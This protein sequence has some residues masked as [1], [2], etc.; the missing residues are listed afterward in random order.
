APAAAAPPPPRR[1]PP[2][3]SMSLR[4]GPEEAPTFAGSLDDQAATLVEAA[5]GG[6]PFCAMCAL[7]ALALAGGA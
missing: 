2:G 3:P 7:K 1:P 5:A 4:T 6:A